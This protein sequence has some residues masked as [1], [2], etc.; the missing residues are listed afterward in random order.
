MKRFEGKIVLVTGASTGIGL[1]TIQRLLAEGGVVYAAHRR[2]ADS[3]DLSGS[4]ID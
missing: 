4:A 3:L 2:K 1:E